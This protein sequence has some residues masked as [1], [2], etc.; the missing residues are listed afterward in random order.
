MCKG[1]IAALET[2]LITTTI[3]QLATLIPTPGHQV[4]EQKTTQPAHTTMEVDKQ[5][6]QVLVADN[7]TSI[8]TEIK[9]TFLNVD[10]PN[11]HNK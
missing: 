3:Q 4:A 7:T 10:N 11:I 6:I 9:H 2:P 1:T 8:A 5:S